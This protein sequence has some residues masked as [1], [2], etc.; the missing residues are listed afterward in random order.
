MKD[1]LRGPAERILYTSLALSTALIPPAAF[2]QE[3]IQPEATHVPAGPQPGKPNVPEFCTN[4]GVNETFLDL[5]R[6]QLT[7]TEIASLP[8]FLSPTPQPRILIETDDAEPMQF[9]IDPTGLGRDFHTREQFI[10]LNVNKYRLVLD[11][12]KRIGA[13]VNITN[14]AT[15]KKQSN[16]FLHC[17]QQNQTIPIRTTLELA[18]ASTTEPKPAQSPIP[19]VTQTIPAVK[20]TERVTPKSTQVEQ[21]PT[22]LAT[23]QTVLTGHGYLPTGAEIN[24]ENQQLYSGKSFRD[25]A[26]EWLTV[27]YPDAIKT[28]EFSHTAI[29][30]AGTIAIPVWIAVGI[31]D[32]NRR[33]RKRK[34]P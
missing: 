4:V 13:R 7:P 33:L 1:I 11:A 3:H 21:K 27:N 30:F 34:K 16:L 12:S 15:R 18:P 23:T 17:N 19:T 20:P 10:P 8:A 22:A 32:I 14:L 25:L 26:M 5:N 31:R 9:S 24:A 29:E 6:R 28:M 2:A